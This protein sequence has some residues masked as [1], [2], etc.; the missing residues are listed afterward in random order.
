MCFPLQASLRV[1][2][3]LP[4]ASVLCTLLYTVFCHFRLILK[5]GQ[6]NAKI[7][8]KAVIKQQQRSARTLEA[9]GMGVLGGSGGMGTKGVRLTD[10]TVLQPVVSWPMDWNLWTVYFWNFPIFFFTAKG[11]PQTTE[12]AVTEMVDK[13]VLLQS[14]IYCKYVHAFIASVKL[15]LKISYIVFSHARSMGDF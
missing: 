7:S 14:C 9:E 12:T 15:V 4:D 3:R 6:S 5:R 13:G 2:V 8:I 11:K 10:F 1:Y